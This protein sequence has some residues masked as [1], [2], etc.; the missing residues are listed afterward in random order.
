MVSRV[1]TIEPSASLADAARAMKDAN[2]GMLPVVDEGRV[3]GVITDR[4]IVLRGV[5]RAVDVSSTPV[6]TA[7]RAR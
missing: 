6:G 2:V 5:A 1:V 3:T 7:C 4:D